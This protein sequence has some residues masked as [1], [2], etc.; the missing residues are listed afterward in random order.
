MALPVACAALLYE[1]PGSRLA[2]KTASSLVLVVPALYVVQH[3]L[4]AYLFDVPPFMTF[5]GALHVEPHRIPGQVVQM[6]WLALDMLAYGFDVLLLGSQWSGLRLDPRPWRSLPPLLQNAW[7]GVP[8]AAL[9]LL[10][11][12]ALWHAPRR[13][14]AQVLGLGVL[15][16]AANATLAVGGVLV[17]RLDALAK[18][19]WSWNDIVTNQAMQPRYQYVP[20]LLLAA[21][22][23]L[24]AESAATRGNAA[25]R[26]IEIILLAT[27]AWLALR[28]PTD[29]AL[30][31]LQ[32]SR[33][34]L[35]KNALREVDRE[36]QRWPPRST[37]YL[38]NGPFG[39]TFLNLHSPVFPGKAAL[40]V[41]AHPDGIVGGRTVRF[42]ERDPD[43][44]AILQGQVGTPISR[45]VISPDAVPGGGPPPAP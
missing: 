29:R 35:Y 40:S 5:V 7:L 32:V 44:L 1:R 41:I 17:S 31:A 37:V 34:S 38:V 19:G 8:A 20:S 21:S 23:G 28:A 36:V 3:A 33:M 13:R 39:R 26:S 24:A 12:W 11:T 4:Y 30:I 18:L 10:A 6:G 27:L 2:W 16:V 9:V 25:R 42:V 45:L 22:L 15:A 14:R 43:L